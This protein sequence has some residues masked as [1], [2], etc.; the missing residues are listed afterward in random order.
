M[1]MTLNIHDMMNSKGM[2]FEYIEFNSM[3]V[4]FV[5]SERLITSWLLVIFLVK[6]QYYVIFGQS[7]C[8]DA[9]KLKIAVKKLFIALDVP[10]VDERL[11]SFEVIGTLCLNML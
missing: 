3:A 6:L 9:A 2:A 8:F 7:S 4:P 1:M 5:A 11:C 10:A